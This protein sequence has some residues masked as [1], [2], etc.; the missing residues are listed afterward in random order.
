MPELTPLI[1]D[2]KGR[3]EAARESAKTEEATKTAVVLPFL[4]MLGYDVFDPREVVPE[5]VADVGIKKG[6]KIDYAVMKDG[7]VSMLI[8]VKSIGTDLGK[9]HYSQLYRYFAVCKAS[10]ALLTNGHRYLFFTDIDAPNKMDDQ[11]FF[12][13]DLDHHADP[14]LL[15][16]ARFHKT[17]FDIDRIRSS[18][19]RLK[20]VA[21]AVE[22]LRR[23]MEEPDDDFVRLVARCVHDGNLT[24]KVVEST[25]PTVKAAFAQLVRDR[26][27]RT[28]KRALEGPSETLDEIAEES[29][30]ANE[31][32]TTEQEYQGYYIVRAI[33]AASIDSNRVTLRDAKSYCAVLLDDNNRKPLCRLHFNGKRQLYVGFFDEAKSETR[34]AIASPDELYRFADRIQEAIARYAG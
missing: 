16:L 17:A 2:L 32:E 6:E 31:I 29:A 8:E 25:R 33:A 11:P 18:A 22:Y 14:D 24:A 21:L 5:F 20:H 28:W 12:E 10:V 13:F 30:P 1:A 15:E 3:L 7:E 4:R 27:E 34:E 23:Q 9:T 19:S 26:L